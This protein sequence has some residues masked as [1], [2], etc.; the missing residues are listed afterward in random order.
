MSLAISPIGSPQMSAIVRSSM[1]T[2]SAIGFSRLP[3]QA[4]HGTSR[5]YPANFSR[6]ES[7]SA[8]ACRR[9]T[10]GMAPSNWV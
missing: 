10:Y 9:S 7:L 5:M 4:G 1:V 2:D 6:L 3:R 8:S